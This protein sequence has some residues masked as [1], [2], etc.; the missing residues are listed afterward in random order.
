MSF[1]PSYSLSS[2]LETV[3]TGKQ[4][5]DMPLGSPEN[6][7]V[8]VD[9]RNMVM[10]NKDTNLDYVY[11]V[12]YSLE[13]SGWE[14]KTKYSIEEYEYAPY[15]VALYSVTLSG[16]STFI[17]RR[18]ADINASGRSGLVYIY[19]Q[20]NEG[21]WNQAQDSMITEDVA[22]EY[23]YSGMSVDIDADLVCAIAKNDVYI[24]R[25][26][27]G[28]QW[29]QIQ[30]LNLGNVYSCS[31]VDNTIAMQGYHKICAYQFNEELGEYISLQ[32]K[33]ILVAQRGAYDTF[34]SVR[35]TKIQYL[36]LGL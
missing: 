17:G 16:S 28:Q 30:H 23:E 13:N 7:Q 31:V 26:D 11:A 22:S 27:G 25:K 32:V 36:Q 15:W 21:V 20:D 14:R 10:V 18:L 1:T 4:T 29:D 8:A 5:L 6:P 34:R 12:F 35:H 33:G 2:C 24:F 19:E 3:L 9:G